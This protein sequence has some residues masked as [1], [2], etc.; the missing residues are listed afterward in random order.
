MASDELTYQWVLNSHRPACFRE[1]E[2][3][4]KYKLLTPFLC[5]SLIRSSYRENILWSKQTVLFL[6]DMVWV[7][8]TAAAVTENDLLRD[9]AESWDKSLNL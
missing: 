5:A 3:D 8:S 7:Y 9:L 6:E 2:T 1:P 4:D